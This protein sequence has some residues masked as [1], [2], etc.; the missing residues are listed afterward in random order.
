M[1]PASGNRSG[2]NPS[3]VGNGTGL[4]GSTSVA[5]FTTAESEAVTDD[6]LQATLVG[7]IGEQL[8]ELGED[9]QVSPDDDLVMIGFDSVAYV[10]LVVFIQ[11][12]FGIDVP[13][14]DVT[15]EHFGSVSTM[16]SYLGK[17]GVSAG[18]DPRAGS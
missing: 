11:D 2:V 12:R 16:V 17:L 14:T 1:I 13:D 4:V 3:V 15:I 5:A 7:Y 6:A 9:D 8:R 18:S 10:R